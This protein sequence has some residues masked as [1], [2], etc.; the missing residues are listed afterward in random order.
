MRSNPERIGVM[1]T[2]ARAVANKLNFKVDFEFGVTRSAAM[3][4]LRG[5]NVLV[6]STGRMTNRVLEEVEKVN[7]RHSCEIPCMV[8]DC[9]RL[10]SLEQKQS[11][12]R[13]DRYDLDYGPESKAPLA[14]AGSPILRPNSASTTSNK[15]PHAEK[16]QIVFHFD[17]GGQRL[18]KFTHSLAFHS[19]NHGVNIIPPVRCCSALITVSYFSEC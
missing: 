10:S 12:S 11:S 14:S 9:C 6:L 7:I 15:F 1:G 17:S 16:D 4:A 2:V 5:L 13:S 19:M 3:A 18:Y 8:E